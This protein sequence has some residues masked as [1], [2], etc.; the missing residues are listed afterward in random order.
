ML[1][2]YKA[3]NVVNCLS[4]KLGIRFGTGGELNGWYYLEGR[5]RLRVTVP[6][7]HGGRDLSP[8]VVNKI[9]GKLRINKEEFR[10]L[11]R[12]PM[13]GSDYEQKIRSLIASGKL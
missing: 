4:D 5:K 12:C 2:G 8:N 3:R 6:K 1:S 10:L 13:T 9:I 11:Y 7:E